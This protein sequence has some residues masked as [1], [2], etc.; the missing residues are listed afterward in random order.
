MFSAERAQDSWRPTFHRND[1]AA[2]PSLPAVPAPCFPHATSELPWSRRRSQ[3]PKPLVFRRFEYGSILPRQHHEHGRKAVPILRLA[4][5]SLD[6]FPLSPFTPFV[7]RRCAFPDV[8]LATRGREIFF[9]A[10]SAGG[11]SI[12]MIDHRA[13][14]IQE[15]C[16]GARP[17]RVIIGKRLSAAR[18]SCFAFEEFHH[19]RENDRPVAPS[20]D[21]LVAP[22]NA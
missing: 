7:H 2:A 19:R 14:F 18:F 11:K 10:C 1:R 3:N 9:C 20:A 17:M 13:Q 16:T 15:W 12:D 21:P 22:E 4:I 8:A 6:W 5:L